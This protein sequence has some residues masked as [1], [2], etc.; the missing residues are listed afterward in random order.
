MN[1]QKIDFVFMVMLVMLMPFVMAKSTRSGCFRELLGRYVGYQGAI[2]A[3]LFAMITFFN[4]RPLD[5]VIRDPH[6]VLLQL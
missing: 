1:G 3:Y 5:V 2:K 4:S 6:V